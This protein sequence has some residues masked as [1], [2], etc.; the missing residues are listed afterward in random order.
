MTYFR[1]DPESG[2]QGGPPNIIHGFPRQSGP[3]P[4]WS[5][6]LSG[7][8]INQQF[9]GDD[10]GVEEVDA[11]DVDV[12]IIDMDGQ[13]AAGIGYWIGTN[14]EIHT[15]VQ[16]IPD[17]GL[18]YYHLLRAILL[19][20]VK[21]LNDSGY[22]LKG[23]TGRDLIPDERYLP[24]GMWVR[25]L[26]LTVEGGLVGWEAWQRVTTVSGAHADA[27]ETYEGAEAGIEI[28]EE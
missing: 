5:I 26:S 10:F 21:D 19:Q 17:I 14:L 15:Y 18:Y 20:S 11:D 6:I 24:D 16:W 9:I 22:T 13:E 8:N 1:A 2:E 3:F 28:I 7:D 25:A 23:F 12:P 4:C 27:G